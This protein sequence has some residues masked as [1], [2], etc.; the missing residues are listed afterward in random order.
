V[1]FYQTFFSPTEDLYEGHL[2]SGVRIE[3]T[4]PA[5]IRPV[6]I[7]VQVACL[8][9]ELSPKDFELRW[10]EIARVTGSKDFSELYQANKSAAEILDV[11]HKSAD[12]FVK[13]RQP[14]LLY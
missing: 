10:D 2:C 11:F 8:L 3:V 14:Y 7:F 12:Q 9:R 5:L 6:D 4:D 13:D 1:R